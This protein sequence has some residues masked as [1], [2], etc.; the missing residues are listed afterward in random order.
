M[1]G[2]HPDKVADLIADRILDAVMETFPGY[3]RPRVACEVLV[4]GNQV[5]LAGET[6]HPLDKDVVEASTRQ[7]IADVG[8]GP[9]DPEFPCDGVQI[10]NLIQQQSSEIAEMVVEG[11]EIGAGDQGIIFGFAC[12]QTPP[13]MPLPIHLAHGLARR[14]AEVR[15]QGIIDYLRP[16]GKT[17]VTVEYEGRR[18]VRVS[19]VVVSAHHLK[20]VDEATLQGDIEQEVIRHVVPPELLEGGPRFLINHSGSFTA[21][22]PGADTGLTGRKLVVDTYGGYGP[23]GGGALSGKDPTKVDRSASYAARHAAKNLVAAG[24]ATQCSIQLSYVIGMHEPLSL[25]VDCFNTNRVPLEDLENALQTVLSFRP[26]Q[27]IENLGL[28]E[29]R[30]SDTTLY[31]HFGREDAGFA[32]ERTDLTE[33][34]KKALSR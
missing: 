33:E 11:D 1:A 9:A 32:W 19:Q 22:G 10:T 18:P 24:L 3:P 16:D 7:A 21:G 23:H 6:S 31:G 29:T 27:M 26:Q 15:S 4:T 14:L 2:G 34:L 8:Y 28:W 5:V 13:L 20:G 17:Q 25:H 12:D 30:F